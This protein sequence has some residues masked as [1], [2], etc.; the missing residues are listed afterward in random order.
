MFVMIHELEIA[1]LRVL[2]LQDCILVKRQELLRL[3]PSIKFFCLFSHRLKNLLH[4][5]AVLIAEIKWIIEQE[6]VIGQSL[7][8]MMRIYIIQNKVFLVSAPFFTII[9]KPG[10]QSRLKKELRENEI[11]FLLLPIFSLQP[12]ISVFGHVYHVAMEFSHFHFRIL[13]LQI[14]QCRPQ[15]YQPR[16]VLRHHKNQSH[17]NIH[18]SNGSRYSSAS[19][20]YQTHRNPRV[21][22]IL[23]S[24]R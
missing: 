2:Q 3:R 21:F 7:I 4:N 6:K 15:L 16:H 17:I 24:Y 11:H 1:T 19:S 22:S 10:N 8:Q 23:S 12:Y 5:N 14:S 13:E 9:V 20:S 18:S